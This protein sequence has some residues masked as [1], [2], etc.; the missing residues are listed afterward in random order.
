LKGSFVGFLGEAETSFASILF[1]V[2][3]DTGPFRITGN[4]L[5]TPRGHQEARKVKITTNNFGHHTGAKS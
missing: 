4:H 3:G 2:G 1:L 5:L